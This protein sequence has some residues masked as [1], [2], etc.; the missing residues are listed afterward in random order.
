MFNI[1]LLLP[2]LYQILSNYFTRL[3]YL[4]ARDISIFLKTS[5]SSEFVE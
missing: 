4:I 2:I 3:I 1:I 5:I